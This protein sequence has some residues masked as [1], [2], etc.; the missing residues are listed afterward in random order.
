MAGAKIPLVV[1]AI[2]LWVTALWMPAYVTTEPAAGVA[3][4][5]E[6]FLLGWAHGIGT[7]A[8]LANFWSL[9][10][11]VMLFYMKIP[12]IAP[13][14][15]SIVGLVLSTAMYMVK[16]AMIVNEATNSPVSLSYGAFVWFASLLAVF[17]ACLVSYIGER[18]FVV[19]APAPPQA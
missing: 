16:S 6:C 17:I 9:A 5:M 7:I 19:G 3:E 13:F 4:G 2:L 11:I 12:R 1:L 15:F 14:I 10:A 18:H 8:W